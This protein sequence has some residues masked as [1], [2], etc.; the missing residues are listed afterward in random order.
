M[1]S[2][3][4]I[5]CWN[6]H[7]SRQGE[8]GGLLDELLRKIRCINVKRVFQIGEIGA[9]PQETPAFRGQGGE[10]IDDGLPAGQDLMPL[11]GQPV[12]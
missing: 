4:V 12:P 11:L 2:A 1:T 8:D 3:V 9:K 10:V 5:S 6:E 7:R